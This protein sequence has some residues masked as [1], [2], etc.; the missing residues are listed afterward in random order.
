MG[1]DKL[2]S[3]NQVKRLVNLVFLVFTQ[4]VNYFSYLYNT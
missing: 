4:K 2:I 1:V 3:W